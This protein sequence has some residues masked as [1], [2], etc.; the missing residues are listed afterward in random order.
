MTTLVRRARQHRA[1]DD[2]DVIARSCRCSARADLLAD[3]LEI[4]EV[5]AAVLPARRADAE[6]RDVGVADG[7]RRVGRRAQASFATRSAPAARRARARRSG[8]AGVDRGDL[9]GVDVD[10][11]DVVTVAGERRRRHAAD[12]PETED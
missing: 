11:D 8:C 12:V 6:Q 3:A 7:V 9:V 10:A 1:A 2:D 5:E 4:R